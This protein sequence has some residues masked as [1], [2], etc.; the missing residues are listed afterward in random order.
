MTN[1]NSE[2]DT[3]VESEIDNQIYEPEEPSLTKYNIALCEKYNRQN[4]GNV[5]GEI[6]NHY[7]TLIRFTTL[8]NNYIMMLRRNYP[9]GKIEIAECLYLSSDHCIS[10]LKT[11]WL[12][13]IQKTWKKI[14]KNRK[15]TILRRL[16][17]NALKYREIYGKWPN[18]C[19]SFPSLKGMLS[20]LS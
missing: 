8:D 9:F 6:N 14:F 11:H 10:I 18:S 4:H 3:D 12:R 19:N 5:D 15:L 1:Y 13:L 17:P 7:L 2:D 16:Y 20:N